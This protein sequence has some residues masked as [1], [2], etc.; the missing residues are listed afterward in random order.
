MAFRQSLVGTTAL[1][2][3]KFLC[4]VG[5]VG[6]SAE[7]LKQSFSKLEQR[8]SPRHKEN[9]QMMEKGMGE[10]AKVF[11]GHLILWNVGCCQRQLKSALSLTLDGQGSCDL[12]KL[13]C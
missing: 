9:H 3:F 5:L 11:E 2:G 10:T 4:W 6:Q 13:I 1:P 7:G 8:R 12:I